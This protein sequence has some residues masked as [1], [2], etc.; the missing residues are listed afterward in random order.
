MN[1]FDTS[2]PSRVLQTKEGKKDFVYPKVHNPKVHS[3]VL[4]GSRKSPPPKFME[5]KRE[6]K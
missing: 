5:R 6:G 1:A 4:P 3:I 2:G